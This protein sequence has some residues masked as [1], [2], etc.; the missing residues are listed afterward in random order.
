VYGVNAVEILVAGATGYIGRRLVP[1]LL[2][3]GHRV[4][5]LARAPE[6]AA[7]TLP[8][9]VRIV[10]GDVLRPETLEAALA[11]VEAAY[12]LVHSMEGDEFS[13]EERDRRAARNFGAAAAAAGVQRII[14]LGGLGN[15]RTR[16]SAHLRSRQEV[17]AILA[18][19]GVPVTE[20]RAAVIIGAGGAS[21]EMLRELTERLPVMVCPRWVTSPIQPIALADVLAYLVR[22][23]DVPATAGRVLEIGGP[24]VMTYQQMMQRFARLRGT[25]RLIVRVPVL[26]PR[27][28]SYWVDIVTSVPAAVARP[29][30]EGLRSPVVVRDPSARELLPLP[31]TSFDDAVRVALAESRPGRRELPLVWVGRVPGR[32]RDVLR[33][34]VWPPVL[35]DSRALPVAAPPA[36]VYREFTRIGGRNGWYY[37]DWAWRLRG[38]LDRLAGGPGLDRLT[39]YPEALSPGDRRDFWHVLEVDAGRRLRMRALM[40]LPGVAELEWSVAPRLGGRSTLYQTARF[41]PRGPLGRVYWYGLY[42]MHMLIFRGMAETIAR[43]AERAPRPAHAAVG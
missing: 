12:Y 40:R 5:A 41:R 27:L 18:A 8:P 43:R 33:D 24:E 15:E 17:G 4:R 36:A 39:P 37:L 2:A 6:R 16:L 11:G 20:F 28:S 30:I 32:L 14:Y 13:F 23:L 10:P 21:F 25:R 7:A 19:S 34:R 26:T 22:C 42:P 31:L 1:A 3:A 38:G 29:L 35:S 9:G